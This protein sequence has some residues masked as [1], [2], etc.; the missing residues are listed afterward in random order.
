MSCA[1]ILLVVRYG[2]V[3]SMY[4]VRHTQHGEEERVMLMYNHSRS[5]MR[6]MGNTTQWEGYP[7][8]EQLD[9]DIMLGNSYV[10]CRDNTPVG[11]FA[12][13]PGIEPTYDVIVHGRWIDTVHPYATVHRLACADGVRGIAKAAFDHAKSQFAYVRFDTHESNPVMRHVAERDGFVY[14]GIVF[15]ADSTERLAYEWWR[16][17]EVDAALKSYVEESVLP[18][19]DHFDA[20][21]RREHARRVIARSILLGTKLGLEA[22]T[23]YVAA[24]L[25]DVGLAFGRDVHHL[26][27]GRMVRE[28]QLLHQWFDQQT[29]EMI[30]QAVEDHRASAN[31]PPR[32]LYGKVLA[33]ADRD[34]EPERI[35]RRTVEYGMSHYPELDR[36]GH[37]QRTLQH[38]QEKYSSQGYI[39]LWL[40]ESPNAEALA[41]L[42]QLI[43]NRDALRVL[44][45]RIYE[46]ERKLQ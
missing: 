4:N 46:A 33:E 23:L 9:R 11:T 29:I 5:V 34:V 12:L 7:T 2:I 6:S 40:E 21:H 25:H 8:R 30:A 24:A 27:G 17:D 38:L 42:R 3:N 28:T 31:Q 44:F 15:M 37:W 19:Y 39:K 41:E 26:E 22:N 43:K 35:V 16:W 14:S 45:D 18:Q 13:V 32:S 10:V 1:I 36:E 20:A